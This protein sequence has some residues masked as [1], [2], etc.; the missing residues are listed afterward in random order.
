MLRCLWH[1]DPLEKF[2][3]DAVL[4]VFGVPRTREDD[5][6]RAVRAAAMLHGLDAIG[7]PS[8]ALPDY[9]F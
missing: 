2:V 8:G 4:A 1:G 9:A 7:E 3:R 5:A 6:L